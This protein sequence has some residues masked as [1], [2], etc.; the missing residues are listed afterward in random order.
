MDA[1]RNVSKPSFRARVAGA[2]R[3]RD[4]LVFAVV[5]IAIAALLARLFWLGYRTAHWDEARVAY[6][7][8]RYEET[9]A[10]VYRSIIHGPFVHHAT[11]PLFALF[12]PTDFYARLPVALVG[13]FLPLSALLFREHLRDHET[14]FLA[15]LLALNPILLYYSRF[16]RS[17]V[18]VAAFMLT[19]LGFLVRTYDTRDGRYLYPAALFLGFGI[20][21]K[22][23]ALIYVLTW[24]GAG[25]LLLDTALFRPRTD[26]SGAALLRRQIGSVRAGI[27]P[28]TDVRPIVASGRARLRAVVDRLPDAAARPLSGLAARAASGV[29]VVASFAS[30]VRRAVSSA[31]AVLPRP[32]R[33]PIGALYRTVAWAVRRLVVV[34]VSLL[35]GLPLH[36]V[37]AAVL[38]GG[39]WLF[40]FAPRGAAVDHYPVSGSAVGS[41]TLGDAISNP[42]VFPDLVENTWDYW[43]S[44]YPT[45]SD[46]ALS[47]GEDSS[48]LDR[49]LEFAPQYFDVLKR[50]ALPTLLFAGLGFLYERYGRESSRNLVLFGTY[51]GVASVIGYPLGLDIFGPWNA[52]HPAVVL[53]IPAAAGLGAFYRWGRNAA[54]DRDAVTPVLVALLLVVVFGHVVATAVGAAYV[55][56]TDAEENDLIQYGQP[57]GDMRYD[58]Q[59]IDRIAAENDGTD[60][61][62]FGNYFVGNGESEYF[63]PACMGT[64]QWFDGL[65][66]PWYLHAAGADV[67]CIQTS[68]ELGPVSG[69]PPPV[70]ITR[71]RSVPVLTQQLEGIDGYEYTVYELRT[72]G[73][74]TAILID[75]SALKQ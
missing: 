54:T 41:V 4:P 8:L 33:N 47:S 17:D 39:V 14:V 2:L 72:H 10:F 48:L 1:G 58:L 61:L 75:P 44:E 25:A 69:D 57:A 6:W 19:A 16:L 7:I 22:E 26:P 21:S 60:V 67:T 13:G 18:L 29:A 15:L 40:T 3:G 59:A 32:L 37:G 38:L 9:G 52:A 24:L 64:S 43:Y 35:G 65:P 42:L 73:T 34:T 20:A 50:H 71:E 74:E 55:H 30:R 5:A 12:G 23:N 28:G 46:K 62:L 11:R 66:L 51:A 49:Y 36:V 45:W 53:T 70:I 56:D 31:V 63:F 68:T 27:R